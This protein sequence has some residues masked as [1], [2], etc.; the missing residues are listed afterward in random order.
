MEKQ[1]NVPILRSKQ[2]LKVINILGSP[3]MGKSAIASGLYYLMKKNHHSV[4]LSREYAKYAIIAGREWQLKEEQLYLFAKQH[5]ELFI[6]RGQYE[7]AISDS[8]LMLTAFY[9]SPEIAPPSF[10]QC[11]YDYNATFE[12][13][14]F[15]ISRDLAN[16]NVVFEDTARAHNRKQSIKAEQDLRIFLENWN[17]QYTDIQ[18]SETDDPSMD[19]AQLIYNE[20]YRQGWLKTNTCVDP[21]LPQS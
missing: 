3:G 18:V 1:T 15:F 10:F 13:I 21:Q 20:L 7:H 2:P 14:N 19:S 4:G 5:H 17:I 6:L 12:S 16:P 9:S 8:P 11:V